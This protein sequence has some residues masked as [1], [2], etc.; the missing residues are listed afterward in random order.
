MGAFM[1]GGIFQVLWI[2]LTTRALGP[3]DMG[4]FGPLMGLFWA[5]ASLIGL[6]IPQTITTFV[7]TT[8]KETLSSRA[9]SQ[10]MEYDFYFL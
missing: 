9:G 10:L 2:Q 7:A 4:L 8:T 1:V 6:G 5:I 3:K